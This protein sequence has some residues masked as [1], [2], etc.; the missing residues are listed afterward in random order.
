MNPY[1]ITGPAQIGFS[2][3]RGSGY[4]LYHLEAHDG[5]LPE[6]VH[7]TFQNAGKEQNET[8][9]FIRECQHH[10]NVPIT[11]L[12]FDGVYDQGLSWKIVS[13]EKASRNGEPYHKLGAW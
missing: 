9:D 5:K 6:G 11:W 10:W 8:L 13:H 12:E 7:V 3:G 2:G 4:M 1:Q